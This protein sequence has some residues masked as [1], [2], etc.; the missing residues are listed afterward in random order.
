MTALLTQTARKT[1]GA[2]K[3]FQ[4]GGTV[5]KGSYRVR[6]HACIHWD[7]NQKFFLYE[8]QGEG[9]VQANSSGIRIL[10]NSKITDDPLDIKVLWK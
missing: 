3:S 10:K 1:S 8:S 5:V 7:A 6:V 2:M 9:G 4:A